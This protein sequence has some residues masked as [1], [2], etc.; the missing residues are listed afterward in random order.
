MHTMSYGEAG[1]DIEMG[2][3][4]EDFTDK[5]TASCVK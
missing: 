2:K 4:V 1:R 5:K 3:N